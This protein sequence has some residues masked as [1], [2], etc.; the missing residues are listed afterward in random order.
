MVAIAILAFALVSVS[1]IVS[2]SLRSQVLARDLD[3]AALLARGKMAELTEKYERE[4]FSIGGAADDGNFDDE[5]H[6]E[7]AW[8][9]KVLEPES[10]L[11]GKALA[12]M[13]VGDAG[14]IEQLLKPKA[15]ENGTEQVNAAS[16]T[17][18]AAIETQLNA[19][20]ATVKQG[21]RELRLTVSWKEGAREESFD[22]VTHLVVFQPTGA[23]GAA[24]ATGAVPT[25]AGLPPAFGVPGGMK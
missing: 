23:A 1:D 13:L 20:A 6:P 24:P 19:F 14:G 22:V 18:A 16:A 2:G 21:V 8:K 9:M 7:I 25:T 5:G 4:G 3:V 12:G 10:S 15:D 17:M 11:D